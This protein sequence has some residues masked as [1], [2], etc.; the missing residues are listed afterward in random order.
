MRTLLATVAASSAAL[1]TACP[2][3]P[4]CGGFD[5]EGDMAFQRGNDFAIVCSNGGFSGQFDG[6][7]FE[8]RLVG[9][10]VIDG[11]TG[12]EAFEFS[13]YADG[14][15]SVA[16]DEVQRDHADVLCQDLATRRW[17]TATTTVPS[18]TAL[19]KSATAA[20]ASDAELDIVLLCPSGVAEWIPA[21]GASVQATYSLD[22]AQLS[23]TGAPEDLFGT[24]HADGQFGDYTRRSAEQLGLACD[25]DRMSK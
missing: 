15:T 9:S 14:W 18:A 22:S 8:G 20:P 1:L 4:T 6:A 7:D 12:G 25:D 5:G 2:L 16:M 19:V 3:A 17:W 21:K 23:I 24:Y 11:A 13:Q 10:T